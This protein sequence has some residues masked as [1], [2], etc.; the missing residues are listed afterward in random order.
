MLAT[1]S[2]NWWIFLVRGIAAILFGVAVLIFPGAALA[3]LVTLIAAYFLVDGVFTVIY[4]LQHRS[5]S[6][7]WV[8][9]LEGLISVV[10]S[11]AAF[12]YPGMTVFILLYIVAFW[13][14]LTGLIEIIFAIQMRREISNEWL[15][16]LCG[17]LSVA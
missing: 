16:I 8:V 6:R 1:L 15:M 7:W 4:A 3:T 14:I 5:Q 11:I 9:L 12:V 2:R 10:G 13:A 17:I